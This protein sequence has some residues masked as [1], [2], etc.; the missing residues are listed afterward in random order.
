MNQKKAMPRPLL[1]ASRR[2]RRE[3]TQ[4]EEKLWDCLRNRQ[5]MEA[6]FRRQAVIDR[7]IVDFY[8]HASRLIVE[9]DGGIHKHP[10]TR[11]HDAERRAELEARGYRVVRFR[12]EEVEDDLPAVLS[13]I[14]A[15]LKG[16]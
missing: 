7:F 3:A 8:C 16:G 2:L 10:D 4:A 15:H 1:K 11:A 6:K 9:L 12:N 14:A 13:T 5:L